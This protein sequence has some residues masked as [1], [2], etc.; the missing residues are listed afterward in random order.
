[1][2]KRKLKCGRI[3]ELLLEWYNRTLNNNV[4][5]KKSEFNQ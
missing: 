2:G 1:M 4:I 5:Q 3:Q